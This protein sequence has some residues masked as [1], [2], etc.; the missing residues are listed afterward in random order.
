MSD[1]LLTEML[2]MVKFETH[3]ITIDQ[4]NAK[5][6]LL[7]GGTHDQ[8]VDAF[9][10]R[11]LGKEEQQE[12][13]DYCRDD[14]KDNFAVVLQ[15]TS[16]PGAQFVYF[17]RKPDLTKPVVVGTIAHELLHVTIGILR[18]ADV[19]LTQASEEAFTYLHAHLMQEAWKRL[20]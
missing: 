16:R 10:R 8:H 9:R 15:P 1:P 18:R 6:T 7:I 5:V 13:A 17:P 3:L 19:R 20:T 11:K 4:W 2:R 14:M 12:L